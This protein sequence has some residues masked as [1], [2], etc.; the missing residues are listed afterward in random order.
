MT[1]V[2]LS[3]VNFFA[4]CVLDDPSPEQLELQK[5]A[6]VAAEAPAVTIYNDTDVDI[7]I[8]YAADGG[9]DQNVSAIISPDE[10]FEVESGVKRLTIIGIADSEFYRYPMTKTLK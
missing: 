9:D 5:Q 6:K 10:E 3:F 7:I 1:V 8:V 2:L 4:G